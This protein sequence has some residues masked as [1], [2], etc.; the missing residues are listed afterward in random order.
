[1][2]ES[3][4]ELFKGWGYEIHD[5]LMGIYRRIVPLEAFN[6]VLLNISLK[7]PMPENQDEMYAWKYI[8]YCILSEKKPF[9]EGNIP[10]ES[11]MA[12]VD[13]HGNMFW[14]RDGFR[15]K[16]NPEYYDNMEKHLKLFLEANKP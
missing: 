9:H 2:P 5:P 7:S 10:H 16:I 8:I 4:P 6:K 1:M 15:R 12:M 13:T 14:S 11:L 3:L